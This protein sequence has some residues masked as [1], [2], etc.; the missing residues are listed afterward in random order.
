VTVVAV[1]WRLTGW[2]DEIRCVSRREDAE[3]RRVGPWDVSLDGVYAPVPLEHIGSMADPEHQDP[4]LAE[5]HLIPPLR[6]QIFVGSIHPRYDHLLRAA[7]DASRLYPTLSR[8]WWLRGQWT[9]RP[10]PDPDSLDVRDLSRAWER[11]HLSGWFSLVTLYPI[12]RAS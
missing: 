11:W 6:P 7:V 4:L 3:G 8:R 9:D 5:A 10:L 2:G 12:R 1:R